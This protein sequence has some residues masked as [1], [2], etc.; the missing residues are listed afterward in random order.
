MDMDVMKMAG[1]SV[2]AAVAAVILRRLRPEMGM[3]LSLA[4]GIMLLA[5][6]FPL[7]SEVVSGLGALAKQGGVGD[8][9]L[10]QLL[11]VAGIS[12]L[13]DFAAQTCRDAG[14]DGLALKTELAGRVMLISLALP[15]MRTLLT[16]LLSL[17]P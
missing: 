10:M 6:A 16:R 4:A 8:A 2:L 1:L 13:T 5:M 14:E 11:K 12:L 9:Y 17:A 3:A 7:L 15:A